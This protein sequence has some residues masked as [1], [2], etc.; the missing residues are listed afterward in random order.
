MDIV[1]RLRDY[2]L[3]KLAQKVT[4]ERYEE[5]VQLTEGQAELAYRTVVPYL[6]AGTEEYA[7]KA[8]EVAFG[9]SLGEESDDL[10]QVQA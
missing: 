3:W 10:A 7:R 5:W 6:T 9:A 1:E 2:E 4:P 8:L